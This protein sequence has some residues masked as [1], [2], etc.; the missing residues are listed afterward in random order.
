[1]FHGGTLVAETQKYQLKV[2]RLQFGDHRR[3]TVFYGSTKV[4]GYTEISVI[5]WCTVGGKVGSLALERIL[6]YEGN[7]GLVLILRAHRNNY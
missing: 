6:V 4:A 5:S 2:P 3:L 7:F 1:M